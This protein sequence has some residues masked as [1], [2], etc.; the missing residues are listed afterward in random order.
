[1][2]GTAPSRNPHGPVR[3]HSQRTNS[4]R[5]LRGFLGSKLENC[6]LLLFSASWKMRRVLLDDES[7][8]VTELNLELKCSYRPSQAK[9]GA[10]VC[11]RACVFWEWK[12]EWTALGMVEKGELLKFPL[13]ETICPVPHSRRTT[14]E[15]SNCRRHGSKT[16]R[17][18]HPIG[19]ATWIANARHSGDHWE[20]LMI[21]CR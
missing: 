5:Q 2:V 1:V 14:G 20:G 10:G 16:R 17:P 3:Q 7:L 9:T 13:K 18:R 21:D 19:N 6:W 4:H 12:P 15:S 8:A 11:R